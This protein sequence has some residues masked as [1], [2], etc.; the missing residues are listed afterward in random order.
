ML[1]LHVLDVTPSH[2]QGAIIKQFTQQRSILE[3]HVI[4]FLSLP[5]V[6][7][8][9]YSMINTINRVMNKMLYVIHEIS[10][11]LQIFHVWRTAFYSSLYLL[12]LLYCNLKSILV[13]TTKTIWRDI[14]G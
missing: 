13:V 9:S 11:I 4:Q 10:T 1:L 3:W 12:L 8:S 14:Q 7:F 5:Q 6:C 2:P